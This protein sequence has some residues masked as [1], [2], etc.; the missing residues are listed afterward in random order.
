[1]YEKPWDLTEVTVT[2]LIS[3][4]HIGITQSGQRS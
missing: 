3:F 2:E 1:M 4:S